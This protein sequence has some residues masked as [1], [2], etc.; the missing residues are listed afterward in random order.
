MK[1]LLWFA[2]LVAPSLASGQPLKLDS[3]DK[4]AAKASNT[5]RVTLNGGMLRLAA[6]FLSDDDSD[7]AQIKDLVKGL[8]GIYVRSYE[9][10][11]TGQYLDS[12]VEAIRSQL[13]NSAWNAIVEVRSNEAHGENTEVYAKEQEDHFAGLAILVAEPKELT[14][15]HIDGV[16]NLDGLSKLSGKFGIPGDIGSK[17]DKKQK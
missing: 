1:Y 6:K 3:L 13:K 9:F 14:V 12:D 10:S 8:K 11:Q 17:V 4:L 16:I 2:L 5:V 15:V 7:E